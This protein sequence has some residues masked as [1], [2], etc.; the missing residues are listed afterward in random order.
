MPVLQLTPERVDRH[1]R[2]LGTRDPSSQY[3]LLHKPS[4]CSFPPAM[5]LSYQTH[6]FISNKN[7]YL[8]KKK[9]NSQYS[10]PMDQSKQEDVS[11]I[12]LQKTENS[13]SD[14]CFTQLQ[15]TLFRIYTT[16]FSYQTVTTGIL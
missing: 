5:F 10:S 12:L 15:S 13:V 7:P 8:K 14:L 4:Q 11:N 16:H 2:Q 1:H 3:F 6:M 9:K